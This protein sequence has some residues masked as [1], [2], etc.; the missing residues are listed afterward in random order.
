MPGEARKTPYAVRCLRR[1][2]GE[3]HSGREDVVARAIGAL[4][5]VRGVSYTSGR[6]T[7]AMCQCSAARRGSHQLSLD[8]GR[9]CNHTLRLSPA[10]RHRTAAR[11]SKFPT[12]LQTGDANEHQHQH[13]H[14]HHHHQASTTHN[15][16]TTPFVHGRRRTK[17]ATAS[18]DVHINQPSSSS[19]NERSEQQQQLPHHQPA[20]KL[21]RFGRGRD[22]LTPRERK[23]FMVI[24][25]VES[26]PSDRVFESRQCGCVCAC[27]C[28]R[29]CVCACAH[30]HATTE[31]LL[32]ACVRAPTTP[33]PADVP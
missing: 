17:E 16:R 9:R 14:H 6:Y 27:A 8:K 26:L 19:N 4:R 2:V 29:V 32:C 25:V 1:V 20:F 33:P 3:A 30:S 21:I 18:N 5:T 24:C 31:N 13:H 23:L 22:Q 11:H 10:C 12:C 7:N 15:N 28:E